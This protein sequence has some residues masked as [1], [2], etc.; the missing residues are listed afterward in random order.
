MNWLSKTSNRGTLNTLNRTANTRNVPVAL[1]LSRRVSV[2]CRKGST[3]NGSKSKS[4][5][6]LSEPR[7]IRTGL[8]E[9]KES[10]LLS[11]AWV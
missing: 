8:D 1:G 10:C 5:R 4:M 2:W 9:L 7:T 3:V 11:S 6:G